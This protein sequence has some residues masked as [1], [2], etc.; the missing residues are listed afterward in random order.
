M[1]IHTKKK[2]KIHTHDTKAAKIK[3]SNGNDIMYLH[4]CDGKESPTDKNLVLCVPQ[5]ENMVGTGKKKFVRY[6]EGA[7][8]YSLGLHTRFSIK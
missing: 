7:S 5:L 2:A 8:L 3:G 4:D 1:V 6:A